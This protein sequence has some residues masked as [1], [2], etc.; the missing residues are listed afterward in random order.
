MRREVVVAKTGNPAETYDDFTA[1][2]PENDCRYAVYDFDFVTYDNCRKSK[3]FLIA[4]SP[5]SSRIRAKAT[6]PTEVDL[7]VLKERA[8]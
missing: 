7:K 2:L 8:R 4:W 3:I 6:D 1:S 5:S